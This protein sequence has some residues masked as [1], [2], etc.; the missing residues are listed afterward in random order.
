MKPRN[1]CKDCNTNVDFRSSRCCSCEAKRKVKKGIIAVK[2]IFYNCYD[3]LKDLKR[4][5]KRCRK[6][7]VKFSKGINH[8]GYK[9]GPKECYCIDCGKLLGKS[10]IYNRSKRC[11]SCRSS[12]NLNSN[13]RGGVNR[14]PYSYK[15]NYKLK[16]KIRTRDNFECQGLNC[17]KKERL[18]ALDVHH[19]DYDKN[20]CD[21]KNLISV[22]NP[23]NSKANSNRDYWY[24]Y[25]KYKIEEKYHEIN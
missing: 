21:E 24:A 15:F 17:N 10:S 25:Y 9:G 16:L 20:N 7:H 1:K 13:W 14:L 12:G 8:W 11:L 22:C 19:I 3:C 4:N 23:C 5:S 2:K 6:C 18:R